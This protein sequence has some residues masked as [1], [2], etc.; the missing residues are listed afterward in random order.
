[1]RTSLLGTKGETMNI[2]HNGILVGHIGLCMK[3][4]GPCA[5]C[6]EQRGLMYGYWPEDWDNRR[7]RAPL[8]Q[9]C[10]DHVHGE[11]S[12][13]GILAAIKSAAAK[14]Q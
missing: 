5:V 4:T 11:Y 1:M 6:G 8:T 10:N 9:V 14:A 3:Q 7:V 13:A 12:F 2:H